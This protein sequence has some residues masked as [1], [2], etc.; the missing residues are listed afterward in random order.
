MTRKFQFALLIFMAFT[1]PACTRP[2]TGQ[3]TTA[4]PACV[5]LDLY[6]NV[7]EQVMA[8][9]PD[10]REVSHQDGFALTQ[11]SIQQPH[12][13]HSLTATLTPEG[14]ICATRASSQYK[15]GYSEEKWVGLLQ[16]AAVAPVSDLNFTAAWLE[17]KIAFPC[18]LANLLHR[19]YTAESTMKDGSTWRLSCSRQRGGLE[20][21]SLTDFSVT[22]PGCL[23][24][25]D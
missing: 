7:I 15:V 2:Q 21:D 18:V 9:T 3:N 14:C 22:V 20:A 16:G 4:R 6:D 19:T 1:L 24:V 8:E 11:W 23:P 12:G 25:A 10:W 5:T 13:T 17:P